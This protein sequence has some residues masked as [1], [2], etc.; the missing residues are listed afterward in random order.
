MKLKILVTGG[1]GGLGIHVCENLL[2]EGHDIT[3]FDLK[4]KSNQKLVKNYDLIDY[5]EWGNIL[6][7]DSYKHLLKDQDVIIHLAYILPPWSET[8]PKAYDINVEGTRR[9]IK[10]LEKL[11]SNC[12]FIFSSSVSVFG[13]THEE[14]PPID[15]NY[16]V[17][18]TDNYTTHKIQ[19]EKD[20]RNSNLE[21]VVLRFAEAPY[22]KMDLSLKNLKRMYSIP[23]NQRVEFIHPM[24]VATAVSNAVS[25]PPSQTKQVY[26]I[27]GGSDCQFIYYDQMVRILGIF[28]I[29]PPKKEK[30]L[31]GYYYLDWYDTEQSQNV[32]KFQQRN[33]DDYISD[34]KNELGW[35][36]VNLIKFFSPIAGLLI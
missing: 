19:S 32:L 14:D 26:I 35:W 22:L 25:I 5:V 34:L 31:D 20:L 7:E 18:A 17:N 3:I 27:G 15:V 13:Y 11:N 8:N 4:T 29:S 10:N 33:F 6:D 36:K 16:P 2:D 28:N 12:R 30:F 1:L 21:W 9:L 24:D 23:W